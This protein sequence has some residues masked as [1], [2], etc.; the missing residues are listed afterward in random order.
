M[1]LG[2]S[3]LMEEDRPHEKI[4]LD[5]PQLIDHFDQVRQKRQQ[6]RG[7]SGADSEWEDVPSEQESNQLATDLLKEVGAA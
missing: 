2:F 4:W 7:K 6:E 1:V 3:E 5:E